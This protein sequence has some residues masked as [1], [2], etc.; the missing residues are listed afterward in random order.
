MLPRVEYPGVLL[1]LAIGHDT[2][3]SLGRYCGAVGL[4]VQV[5]LAEGISPAIVYTDGRSDWTV[6]YR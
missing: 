6:T 2:D 3:Q 4:I 5:D 1:R